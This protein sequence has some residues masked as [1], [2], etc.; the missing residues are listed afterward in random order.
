[1]VSRFKKVK[2]RSIRPPKATAISHTKSFHV[3]QLK[4]VVG[5]AQNEKAGK[6]PPPPSR[7]EPRSTR[8]G[9]GGTAAAGFE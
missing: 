1:M 2:A 9:M 7:R 8:A 5:P 3:Y 6:G 4:Q